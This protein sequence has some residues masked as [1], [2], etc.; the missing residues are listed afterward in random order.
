VAV[1]WDFG[2]V[3]FLDVLGFA[4][5]IEADAK[6][7]NPEHLERLFLSL[8]DVKTSPAGARLDVRAFSDSIVVSGALTNEGVAELVEA[9]VELQRLFIRRRVLIRGA[10]AMG[11]HFASTE[12]VYSE[13]LVKAYLLE[14]DAARFPRILVE[15]NLLDWFLNDQ[16]TTAALRDRVTS[17]LLKDRDN[18]AFVSYLHQD[19]L[20]AHLDLLNSYKLDRVTSS[21][22]E[23]VQW[24]ADYHNHIATLVEPGKAVSMPAL[25]GFRPY[26]K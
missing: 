5:F 13:A 26:A 17:K 7:S 22:L 4:A 23:K 11:K 14:R 20:G 16:D 25:A 8:Q 21:V 18:S 24:L 10:V 2:V 3:A 1:A 9:V 15:G 6:S 19:L 12:L